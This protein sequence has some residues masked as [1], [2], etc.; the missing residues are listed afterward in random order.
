MSKTTPGPSQKKATL[1]SNLFPSS[2]VCQT[3]L[4]GPWIPFIFCLP[5]AQRQSSSRAVLPSS[6]SEGAVCGMPLVKGLGSVLW[7]AFGMLA[8]LLGP[9]PAPSAWTRILSHLF[10]VSAPRWLVP[11]RGQVFLQQLPGGMDSFHFGIWVK[12]SFHFLAPVLS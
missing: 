1:E 5:P 3:F 9:R 11:S 10:L 8:W 2:K 12:E 4:L 6:V 7:G